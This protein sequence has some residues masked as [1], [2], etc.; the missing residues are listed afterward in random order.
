MAEYN[1]QFL[2][3]KTTIQFIFVR[4]GLLL[5][6]LFALIFFILFLLPYDQTAFYLNHLASDGQLESFTLSLYKIIQVPVLI[7]TGLLIVVSIY[8]FI[9]NNQTK[10]FLKSIKLTFSNVIKDFL[11]SWKKLIS[12]WISFYNRKVLLSLLALLVLSFLMRIFLIYRPMGHDEAY[13]AVV[14]AFEPLAS[15]LSDYHF[16][17]NH[18]FHTFLVHLNYKLFG[19]VEWA[20]RMPAFIASVLL[21]PSGFIL[22]RR[23]YGERVALLSGILI[24]VLPDTI[25]YAV[26]ARGYSLLALFTLLTFILTLYA[27]QH[28]NKAA[29]FLSAITGGL[30]FYTLPIMAY[31]LAILYAWLA[32]SWLFK[33]Y[34]QEYSRL[35]FLFHI[36]GTGIFTAI[37]GL[38]LYIPIFLNWGFASL[39]ANPYVSAMDQTL[40]SQTILSRFSE[41]WLVLNQGDVPG[42]GYILIAGFFLS[43]IFHWKISRDKIPISFLSLFI[44]SLMLIIQRPNVFNRTWQF[45]YPLASIWVSAGWIALVDAILR[46]TKVKSSKVHVIIT[47]LFA[48]LF[49]INGLTY[50]QDQIPTSVEGY[51]TIERASVYIMD[52]F[53]PED[54]VIIT[55]TDDAPMWYYFEKYGFGQD[56]FSKEKPFKN[57]FIA[58][59]RSDNQTVEQVIL[60][61]GPKL[62]FFDMTTKEK[63]TTINTIDIYK[64]KANDAVINNVYGD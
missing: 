37:I 42:F 53:T 29:W 21:A 44:I 60:E 46:F 10:K 52:Q 28:K 34:G 43:I 16:P 39:F 25:H 47:G 61:R 12:D 36:I 35:S 31:P 19:P 32:L 3:S 57:A 18:V 27:R 2:L 30:G 51:G 23:W 59:S 49:F 26:N 5:L 56:Y 4:V 58:V 54:I 50:L 17:N 22:A 48:L 40:Y 20:V 8:G 9:R 41:S 6:F 38:F 24:A 63:I 62:E 55:A 7:L 1:R 14:F 45:F 64:I 11:H 15:G 13:T 33:L